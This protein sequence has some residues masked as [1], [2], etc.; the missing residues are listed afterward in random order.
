MPD[1]NIIARLVGSLAKG[2]DAPQSALENIGSALSSLLGIDKKIES[3]RN[4]HLTPEAYA[5]Y[6]KFAQ[7]EPRLAE[8]IYRHAEG[9][10]GADL[11]PQSLPEDY[12]Q[13]VL[14]L[15]P[16]SALTGGF[17]GLQ[18]AA[19]GAVPATAAKSFG[20]GPLGQDVAQLLGEGAYGVFKGKIPTLKS[21][22]KAAYNEAKELGKSKFFSNDPI[23]EAINKVGKDSL[24]EAD[25]Q[26]IKS[27]DHIKDKARK[28]FFAKDE[29]NP[30]HLI[31]LRK[32]L[33]K[34][35]NKSSDALN[36]YLDTF[37]KGVNDTFDANMVS[38]PEFYNALRERADKFTALRNMGSY[39]D[40]FIDT[41]PIPWKG[42]PF[43][44]KTIGKIGSGTEKV[45]R[46]LVSS[47]LARKHYFNMTK[48]AYEQNPASFINAANDFL[49][50]VEPS[51]ENKKDT[52]KIVT[53]GGQQ[54]Q[55]SFKV[56]KLG[57]Q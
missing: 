47:P 50:N 33:Y 41:L 14:R 25:R 27:L 32:S 20:F 24:S 4:K 6:Q 8:N 39:V 17:G 3:S 26:V 19:V 36:P 15:A 16:L 45:T 56:I 51:K 42:G 49:A 44:K 11:S 46:R 23:K 57:S 13:R 12:A 9:L 28:L 54:P 55:S 1:N 35:K 48:A 43:L 53:L 7:H 31:D 38:H 21:E 52:F 22:Q 40:K 5:Q 30:N 34:L 10:Q 18:S 2:V 29:V 37:I